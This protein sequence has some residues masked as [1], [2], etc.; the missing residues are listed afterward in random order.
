MLAHLCV[1]LTSSTAYS[2][3]PSKSRDKVLLEL[4]ALGS[5]GNTIIRARDQVLAILQQSNA[6]SSWFREAAP[7]PAGV[8][9]SLHFDVE[10]EGT[11]Y[12][13]SMK[14]T[15]GRQLFKHP[16]AAR[17]ME[18]AG[19]DSVI[20][21]NAHGSFFNSY[22]FVIELNPGGIPVRGTET[23]PP[24]I[25]SYGGNTQ[26]TQNTILLHELGHIIGRLP[27]DDDS[28]DG[29]STRNTS[30]LLKH[31]KHE[32]RGAAHSRPGGSI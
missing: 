4:M 30:V 27:E 12:V 5:R 18:N 7:D 14:D 8:F 22:A 17:S 29:Q 16:W 15:H 1:L 21:L 3:T 32:I 24:A 10:M 23:R 31:C 6:C 13:F 19:P 25:F 2:D 20:Q 26:E 11:S 9:R 28:W